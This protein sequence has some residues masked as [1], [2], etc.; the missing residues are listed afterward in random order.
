MERK[1]M[2]RKGNEYCELELRLNDGRLSICGNAGYVCSERAAKREALEF[3][4][5][6]FEESPEELRAMNE[7]LGRQFRTPRGAAKFVLECDGDYHGLDV[8]HEDDGEVYVCHSCGQIRDEIAR[9]FPEAAAYFKWHLNDMRAEC[10]HQEARGETWQTHPEAKCPDCG[11]V[12]GSK[13][14]KRELPADVI[15]WAETFGGDDV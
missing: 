1:I 12:L 15:T 2:R 4:E 8:V 6:F 13:W 14:L 3:W 10:E 11:Y 7:R 5:S 9:F